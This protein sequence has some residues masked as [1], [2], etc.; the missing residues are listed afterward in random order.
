MYKKV[1]AI[2]VFGV[3]RVFLR[4]INN[5]ELCG[6][7]VC[8]FSGVSGDLLDTL[9][10]CWWLS[11]NIHNWMVGVINKDESDGLL[12]FRTSHIW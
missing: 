11:W 5:V 1:P 10:N 9:V 6:E 4:Y 7:V 8:F 12:V 2:S 3:E